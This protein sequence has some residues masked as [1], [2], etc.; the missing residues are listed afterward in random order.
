MEIICVQKHF[1]KVSKLSQD[2]Q[3]NT[4]ADQTD[5]Y[6]A[7][8]FNYQT[9]KNTCSFGFFIIYTCY[10]IVLVVYGYLG[11]ASI[12]GCSDWRTVLT[13]LNCFQIVLI[14]IYFALQAEHC[15]SSIR[16]MALNFSR[17]ASS[18][19]MMIRLMLKV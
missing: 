13:L 16:E 1:L 2:V 17:F 14:L 7:V 12:N 11:I 4:V 9:L 8:L 6:E 5:H 15:S 18:S 10:S 3:F 19:D